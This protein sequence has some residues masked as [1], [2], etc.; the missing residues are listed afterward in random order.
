MCLAQT[1]IHQADNL[2]DNASADVIKVS[3]SI[4]GGKFI[5]LTEVSFS[6][7]PAKY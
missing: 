2:N 6:F 5:V 4:P 1:L 7:S 3:C